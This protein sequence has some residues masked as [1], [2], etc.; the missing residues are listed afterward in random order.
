MDK[1]HRPN[2]EQ[3]EGRQKQAFNTGIAIWRLTGI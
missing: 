3:K 1:S 2:I